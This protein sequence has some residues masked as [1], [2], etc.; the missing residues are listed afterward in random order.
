LTRKLSGLCAFFRA[1]SLTID[2][3]Q[4]QFICR[5]PTPANT[6][7]I[8]SLPLVIEYSDSLYCFRDLGP[9]SGIVD[10]HPF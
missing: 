9:I 7:L 10:Y 4:T 6:L 3:V 2:I 5:L 1:A 8:M